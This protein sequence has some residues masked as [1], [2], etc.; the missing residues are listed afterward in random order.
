[1][2]TNPKNKM[3]V[4]ALVI[5]L[6]TNIALVTFI[7]TNKP[8]EKRPREGREAAMKEFLKKDVGFDEKQMQQYDTLSKQQKEKM[9]LRFDEMRAGKQQLFQELGR[10]GFGD[11][12]I[13]E[14]AIKLSSNQQDIETNM[15]LHVAAIRKICTA[16]QQVKFDSLFYKVW[17]KNGER[18]KK[19]ENN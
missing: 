12:A 16:E 15:L 9:K 7:L 17:N 11:S 18:K 5:L 8:Q 14:A 19:A 1:M 13:R 3:L 6:L 4:I 2:S 10:Q